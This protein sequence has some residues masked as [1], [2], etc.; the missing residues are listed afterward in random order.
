MCRSNSEL[1]RAVQGCKW[2]QPGAGRLTEA[3]LSRRPA[4]PRCGAWRRG[5]PQTAPPQPLCPG[6]SR[7]PGTPWRLQGGGGGA[8]GSPWAQPA[9]QKLV[10]LAKQKK[11]AGKPALAVA[12][13]LS[14]G[15]QRPL[16]PVLLGAQPSDAA[17]QG[18]GRAA[19]RL[20][21]AGGCAPAAAAA[22]PAAPRPG[23]AS[24]QGKQDAL[25]RGRRQP[26]GQGPQPQETRLRSASAFASSWMT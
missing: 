7:T 23:E 21:G 1:C 9:W 3:H 12:K 14:R 4:S 8:E 25:G 11:T 20:G 24:K 10:N 5:A 18:R 13:V 15:A 22:A 19:A 2:A 17:A 26:A 16:L 6:C